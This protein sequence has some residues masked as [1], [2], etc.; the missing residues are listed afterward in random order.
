MFVPL[1]YRRLDPRSGPKFEKKA[2]NLGDHETF[3]CKTIRWLECETV[4]W[5]R[6]TFIA[7]FPS[8]GQTNPQMVHIE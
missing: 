6:P 7:E 3:P 2:L 4:F 1:N 8:R 5:Q